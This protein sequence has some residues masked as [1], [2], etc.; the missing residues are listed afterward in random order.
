MERGV[1]VGLDSVNDATVDW[2]AQ[3]AARDDSE[4]LDIVMQFALI[5]RRLWHAPDATNQDLAHI[6]PIVRGT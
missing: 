4:R 1:P 3:V 6:I 2:L 5:K